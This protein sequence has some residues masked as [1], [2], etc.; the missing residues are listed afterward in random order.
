M[1]YANAFIGLRFHASISSLIDNIPFLAIA[2]MPK[3][4]SLFKE[5]G[6]R[7]W[8]IK[9]DEI[10]EAT[11]IMHFSQIWRS[12]RQIKKE[13]TKLRSIFQKR[14]LKNF[15]LLADLLGIEQR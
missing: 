11:L 5:I 7:E 12:T 10:D 1:N 15:S 6:H 4:E 9:L 8:Y 3:V 13:L 2:Y 14:A